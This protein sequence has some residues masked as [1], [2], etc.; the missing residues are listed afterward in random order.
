MRAKERHI[1]FV[2]YFTHMGDVTPGPAATTFALL[3]DL[4]S[5]INCVSFETEGSKDFRSWKKAGLSITQCFTLPRLARD[6]LLYNLF[7]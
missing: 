3:C 7:M 1:T 4:V 5:I 2:V 6:L